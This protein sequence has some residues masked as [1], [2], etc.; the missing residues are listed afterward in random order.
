MVLKDFKRS[1][2]KAAAV[3][4]LSVSDNAGNADSRI[5]ISGPRVLVEAALKKAT[6]E[7]GINPAATQDVAGKRIGD[8]FAKHQ[9]DL[10]DRMRKTTTDEFFDAPKLAT[11][12][13][14]NSV[15]WRAYRTRGAG[16]Y[17]FF[18]LPLVFTTRFNMFFCRRSATASGS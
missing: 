17:W 18:G 12:T 8:L 4:T 2:S 9:I 6:F 3:Y 11:P 16:T 5:D 7:V 14:R 13:A 15:V 10:A 1:G